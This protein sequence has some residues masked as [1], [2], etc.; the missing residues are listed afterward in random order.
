M[1]G[2]VDL[3]ILASITRQELLDLF[4]ARVLPSPQRRKFSVHI[5]STT[6][7]TDPQPSLANTEAAKT[8]LVEEGVPQSVVDTL[9]DIRGD[10]TTSSLR[11]DA[12]KVMQG[13]GFSEEKVEALL[14]RLSLKDDKARPGIDLTAYG[15]GWDSVV[16]VE[17]LST[18]K[19]S[20]E[21][22]SLPIGDT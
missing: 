19:N 15:A 9:S 12:I 22:A 18:F 20:L 1:A 4:V 2:H 14:A 16:F 3:D 7:R 8:L 13:A 6:G 10:D 11:D 21:V 5:W 17:D